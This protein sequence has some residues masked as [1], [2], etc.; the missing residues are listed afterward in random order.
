MYYWVVMKFTTTKPDAH[1]SIHMSKCPQ[2]SLTH[3]TYDLR[4][5]TWHL[6]TKLK[7]KLWDIG[8]LL[9]TNEFMEPLISLV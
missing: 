3:L 5:Q 4:Y 8:D 9:P 6:E 1:K 2:Y 7:G